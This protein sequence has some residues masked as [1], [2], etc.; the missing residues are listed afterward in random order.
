MT[1]ISDSIFDRNDK[2]EGGKIIFLCVTDIIFDNIMIGR[3]E[4][5]SFSFV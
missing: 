5:K 2:E 4:A 1:D 3:E